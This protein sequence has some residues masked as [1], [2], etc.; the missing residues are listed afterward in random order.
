MKQILKGLLNVIQISVLLG[1]TMDFCVD[2]RL[3]NNGMMYVNTFIITGLTAIIVQG[4]Y[5]KLLIRKQYSKR[6][7]Y[8]IVYGVTLIIYSLSNLLFLGWEILFQVPFYGFGLLILL[9][10]TPFLRQFIR[11]MEDYETFLIVKKQNNKTF[12][13]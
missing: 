12:L 1:V 2:N 3:F 4:L 9:L 7:K 5:K 11:Q 10:M 13:P 6:L 8:L